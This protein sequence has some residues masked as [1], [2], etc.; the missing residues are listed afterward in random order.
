M[1]G[2]LILDLVYDREDQKTLSQ[3]E[4]TPL[5]NKIRKWKKRDKMYLR[6][7]KNTNTGNLLL[8]TKALCYNATIKLSVYSF[9]NT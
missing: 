2:A 8:I 4:G 9:L 6:S 1:R 3:I 7:Q 5:K